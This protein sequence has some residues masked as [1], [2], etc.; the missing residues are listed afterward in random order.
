M[1][2]TSKEKNSNSKMKNGI[3]KGV[4]VAFG[5]ALGA[6]LHNIALGLVI[7]ILIGGIGILVNSSRKAKTK[8]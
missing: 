1:T 3:P 7:G 4:G 8:I 2:D 6:A 5:V